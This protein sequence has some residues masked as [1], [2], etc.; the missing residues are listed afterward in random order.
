MRRRARFR[1]CAECGSLPGDK[2][3]GDDWLEKLFSKACNAIRGI[4]TVK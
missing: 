4:C 1:R 2:I 3:A